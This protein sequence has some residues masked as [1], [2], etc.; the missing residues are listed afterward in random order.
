MTR[1]Q[2]RMVN[3]LQD[4][5]SDCYDGVAQR[6][7]SPQTFKQTFCEECLNSICR[8]SKGS[9]MKWVQRIRTQEH[10]LLENPV[11]ADP[12]DPK[13]RDIVSQDFRPV[14]REAI[15]LSLSAK[16]NDW[17]VPSEEEIGREAA[18]MTGNLIPSG[19]RTSPDKEEKVIESP[20]ETLGRWIVDGSSGMK[21]EVTQLSNGKFRCTCPSREDPCKHSRLIIDKLSMS[22]VEEPEI[23]T[24]DSSIRPAMPAIQGGRF[25][26]E[27]LN[28]TAPS[29]GIMVGEVPRPPVIDPW[30][31][32]THIENEVPVGGKVS[33]SRKKG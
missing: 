7:M 23:K 13:Y 32:P 9:G 21:Y 6:E 26:P 17:S 2:L 4:L 1:V 10:D 30:A 31:P 15:S 27:K 19:F 28:T 3:P 24:V 25:Q 22:P 11:F 33:F 14:M 16:K 5:W 18:R 8:N 29:S 20:P 12:N